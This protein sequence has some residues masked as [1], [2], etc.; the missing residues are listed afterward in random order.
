MIWPNL[1]NV[2]PKPYKAD[3]EQN[4][5]ILTAISILNEIVSFLLQNFPTIRYFNKTA[6]PCFIPPRSLASTFTSPHLFSLVCKAY[7]TH[8]QVLCTAGL[9]VVLRHP[10]LLQ[11]F[12]LQR[13]HNHLSNTTAT[14]PTYLCTVCIVRMYICMY[15]CIYVC[16]YVFMYVCMY[17]RM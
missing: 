9:V 1:R 15:V 17:V 10:D 6:L 14:A 3:F 12:H 5:K 13:R 8:H 7:D 4:C 16:M 2:P 11:V